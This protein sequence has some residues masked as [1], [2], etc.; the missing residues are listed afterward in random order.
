MKYIRALS[1]FIRCYFALPNCLPEIPTSAWIS[2][3]K[4]GIWLH[5]VPI[6][7]S[8]I[9][10]HWFF[11]ECHQTKA[12]NLLLLLRC[13]SNLHITNIWCLF[14]GVST[15]IFVLSIIL[16]LLCTIK[17]IKLGIYLSYTNIEVIFR[18][19]KLYMNPAYIYRVTLTAW[20]S[21]LEMPSDLCPKQG[22]YSTCQNLAIILSNWL[23][24]AII[25]ANLYKIMWTLQFLYKSLPLIHTASRLAEVKQCRISKHVI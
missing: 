1:W 24:L 18:K 25:M 9:V 23:Y 20:S 13:I 15:F 6:Y 16:L 14:L 21:F 19:R 22:C 11:N 8:R 3:E 2:G 12:L 17:W 4:I 10:F 7:G 5:G